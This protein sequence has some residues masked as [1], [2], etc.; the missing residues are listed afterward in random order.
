MAGLLAMALACDLTRVFSIQ[1]SG[2]VGGTVYSEVG[3]TREHHGLTHDEAGDQ[4]T[5]N[6]INAF[7]VS[8]FATFLERLQQTAEGTGNLLDRSAILASSDVAEGQPH[9]L[10]DYPILVAGRA[11][12]VLRYP[13]VHYRS[14]TRE[15]T[16]KVLLTMLQAVGMPLTS[17]GTGGGLTSEVVSA[18]RT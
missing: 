11:G 10:R 12:G 14:T 7:I 4:P 15:N 8:K 17:F 1:F 5:V 18:I 6:A 9:S 16:S 13:G 3:A 2:S